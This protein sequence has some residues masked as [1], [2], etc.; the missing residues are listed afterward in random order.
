M[1][2]VIDSHLF[3]EV[4]ELS[5]EELSRVFK[6]L[7]RLWEELSHVLGELA[8]NRPLWPVNRVMG[9]IMTDEMTNFLSC[10]KRSNGAS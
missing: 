9:M 1:W 6:E 4:L 10:S 2:L 8:I 7:S 5:G 3:R